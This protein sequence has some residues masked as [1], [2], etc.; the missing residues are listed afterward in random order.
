MNYAGSDL[1]FR[2]SASIQEFS[3]GDEEFT[4]SIRNRW[5][6]E[7][8]AI[9]SGDFFCDVD[10]NWYFA[11]TNVQNG[12]YYA[13]FKGVIA[14]GD[15]PDAKRNVTDEQLLCTVGICSCD[16]DTEEC[17]VTH[18]VTYTQVYTCDVEGGTF[19]CDVD[20]KYIRDS[21]GDRIEF[22]TNS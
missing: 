14:D 18:D 13:R 15:M 19:L 22:I 2:V 3:L 17:S 12:R 11:I 20:G 5:G 6:E 21:N 4:I 8:Y 7:K 9:N 1:K 10:G 16:D